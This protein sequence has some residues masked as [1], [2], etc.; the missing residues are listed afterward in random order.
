MG[1]LIHVAISNHSTTL[2]HQEVQ[3]QQIG[4]FDL[5]KLKLKYEGLLKANEVNLLI[6]GLT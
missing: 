1:L 4:Q 6:T 5:Y 3:M 2:V